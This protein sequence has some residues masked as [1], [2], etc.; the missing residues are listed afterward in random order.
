MEFT[1]RLNSRDTLNQSNH[2]DQ[3]YG[4]VGGIQ[5]LPGAYGPKS[6]RYEKS[7]KISGVF[8]M[9]AIFKAVGNF[10]FF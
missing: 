6:P 2:L 1:Y 7:L 3:L 10:S 9:I 5:P 8:F 4:A